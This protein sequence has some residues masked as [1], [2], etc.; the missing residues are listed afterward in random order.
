MR[1]FGSIGSLRTASGVLLLA[2]IANAGATPVAAPDLDQRMRERLAQLPLAFIENHGQLA[3]AVE[4]YLQS[5]SFAVYFH[6]R[7]HQL[8]LL[9][10]QRG[11]TAAHTVSVELLESACHPIQGGTPL[12]GV[13]SYFKGAQADWHTAMR[14]HAGI[15]YRQPWPGID[16]RYDG[17][18]GH[19]ESVYTVAPQADA[20]RIRLR[21]AGQEGLRIA[22]NGDLVYTTSVGEVRE[23]A[24]VLYQEIDGRRIAVAGGYRL[25]DRDTVG[26]RIAAYDR[27]HALVI[28]P[29]LVYAGFLG[30]SGDDRGLGIALDADGNTYVVGQTSTLDGSFPLQSGPDPS[31]NGGQADAFVAKINAAGTAVIYAGF[32]G[33]TANDFGYG[34][35]VDSAGNAYVV[36]QTS[37]ADGSFPA[38]VG[39]DVTYQGGPFDAFVAKVNPAGTALVYSGF[40]GGD[41]TEG[42]DDVAVDTGGSA[43][44]VGATDSNE[45]T[46]PTVVGPDL[47]ANGQNDVYVVKINASGASFA[48]AGFIGGSAT[49]LGRDIA[50]DSAG[51]AYVVGSTSSTESTF[52]VAVGPD[53]SQNG[54]GDDA[55]VAKVN[56]TGS[57][58]V[59]AGFIGGSSSDVG[60]GIAL[61]G[62]GSAFVTGW[63]AST[64]SSFPEVVGPDSSYNG[65][66]FDAF[67]AKL[68]P[69]GNALVYA[70]YIGGGGSDFGV[71]IAVDADGFASV[72]GHTDS[73][74]ATFPVLAGPDSSN[75]GGRD[76]FVARVQPS[77]AALASSGFI[78]GSGTEIG[79]GIDIDRYGNAVV[80]GYTNSGAIDFPISGGPDPSANGGNDAFVAKIDSG[81]RVFLGAFD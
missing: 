10:D 57:G 31:F 43:F 56:P 62:S 17:S 36:G 13:V 59:Y 79:V 55:F 22:T 39:P 8:R 60:F 51:N 46:F 41:G 4:W 15:E 20:S 45:I 35:T 77:G 14:T 48:Y 34:I 26:F 80:T 50:I 29:T 65:G 28:D 3:P 25:L 6:E 72:I 81:D 19:L 58:L 78:G 40:I 21:Y 75:N 32:I 7:G 33:G 70:G 27:A 53:L 64:E 73:T 2:M 38:L 69:S 67:V 30:G 68:S 24:P 74:E 18:G 44:V 49:D 66:D 16:L 52:P 76:A 42:A 47:V 1:S 71:G 12:P 37:S 9:N 63:T 54:G 11:A 61:D 5:A 23:T